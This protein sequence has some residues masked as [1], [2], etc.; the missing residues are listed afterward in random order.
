[1]PDILLRIGFKTA[2]GGKLGDARYTDAPAYHFD[3][4]FGKDYLLNSVWFQKIRPKLMLGFYVWQTYQN[5][6]PQNDAFLCSAGAEI[7]LDKNLLLDIGIGGYY[8]Y[9]GN[10]DKPTMA[11]FRLS[12]TQKRIN[13]FVAYQH[14]IY[15]FIYKTAE[16]GLSLNTSSLLKKPE[17]DFQ[18]N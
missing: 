7:S 6:Y 16:I 17:L 13:F 10:G 4:S 18:S 3:V 8:G 15:D 9:I 5:A 11:R 14:G 12:Q 1:M 2:S